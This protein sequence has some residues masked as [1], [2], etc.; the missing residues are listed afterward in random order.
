MQSRILIDT[1]F[2]R[3]IEKI[4]QCNHYAQS[5][6]II[7]LIYYRSSIFFVDLLGFLDGDGVDGRMVGRVVI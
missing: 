1:A 7:I 6:K 3:N 2:L 5:A 4:K